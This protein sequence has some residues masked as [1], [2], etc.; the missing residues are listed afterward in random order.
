MRWRTVRLPGDQVI[1]RVKDPAGQ[2][3]A[4][5]IFIAFF[6]IFSFWLIIG[7]GVIVLVRSNG[8]GHD[9]Q[10]CSS[11]TSQVPEGSARPPTGE[12]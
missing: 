7:L 10:Y 12:P 11:E 1:S 9:I 3:Q 2:G 5:F 8:V 4:T 6:L